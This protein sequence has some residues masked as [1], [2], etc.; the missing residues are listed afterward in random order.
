VSE[1]TAR[2]MASGALAHSRAQTALA[3][4]GIAGPGGGSA[5]K[6][7]GMVCFAWAL[8]DGKISTQTRHFKG[9]RESVRR[10]SVMLALQG[11]LDLLEG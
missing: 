10:Q 3:I 4:T 1:Q 9:N 6:P 5:D 7:L 11:L 2:E 8:P